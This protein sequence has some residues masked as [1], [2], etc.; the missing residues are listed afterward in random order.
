MPKHTDMIIP[1]TPCHPNKTFN[2][3]LRCL[4]NLLNTFYGSSFRPDNSLFKQKHVSYFTLYCEL[5]MT[6][7]KKKCICNL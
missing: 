3:A 5:Y 7:W 6:T 2:A 4:T 1:F